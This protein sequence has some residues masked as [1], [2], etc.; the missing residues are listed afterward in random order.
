MKKALLALL[1]LVIISNAEAQY[2]R[3]VIRFR[4]KG[5]NPYSL[6]NPLQFL[7]QRAI[8]RRLKYNI[9]LDST[10]LPVTPSYIDGVRTSGAVTILNASKWLNSVTIQ[11]SDAAA[12]AKINSLPYV[13]ST[14]PIGRRI[15]TTQSKSEQP[16]NRSASERT[17]TTESLLADRYNYG[18][19]FKQVHIHNGE[20][21]HNI[22][23]RGDS[24]IMGLLDDG[25]YQYTTLKAFDSVRQANKVL[26][27]WDFVAREQSV[28]EDDAHGEMV[29]SIIA[30]NVPGNM[31]GTAPAASFYLFRTEDATSEYPI[32]EHN[33]VCGAE[34]LDSAGG[35]VISTSLGYSQFDSAALNHTYADMNGNTTMSAIGA[36]MAAKKGIVVLVAA[37]NEGNAAWHYISSP[38]DADSVIAV[39]AVDVNGN[40]GSFSSYG[41][42]SDGQVK[43]DVA[44]VGVGTVVWSPSNVAAAGNGTS[45][46]CPNMAGL[47]TCLWQGFREFNNMAIINAV[48][49]AGSTV[50][51]PNTRIGYG[52]PDMKKAFTILLKQYATATAT[53]INNCNPAVNWTSKDAAGMRYE[54]ER[55]RSTDTAFAKVY[56]LMVSN[57]T[58]GSHSYQFI[59]PAAGTP[60]GNIT[61]R[62]RQVIDTSVTGFYADYLDTVSVNYAGNCN[63]T[64]NNVLVLYPNPVK[65][66]IVIQVN[67]IQTSPV[68]VRIFSMS[69]QRLYEAKLSP[70]NV[71]SGYPLPTTNLA[72]GEYIVSVYNGS[73]KVGTARFIK[74]P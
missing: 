7:S 44:S 65:G 22:G 73:G 56:E 50:A 60:A 17:A 11:T 2:T 66:N 61:Y 34:R 59:D 27:T 46:A 13:I 5:S 55:K 67:T 37:G 15:A 10:D 25:F 35:D 23:L 6:S 14:G 29:F 45:F 39:G 33:W 36:D 42:S 51:T 47:V 32:E 28:I 8:D 20:F 68:T 49:Q 64:A 72:S 19:S 57:T 70:S 30:A 31:V 54:I 62:I 4:N 41:P 53:T 26:G 58:Y 74:L 1:T 48:R 40:V 38:A 71:L 18:F 52:I 24:M 43:P 63:T 21:L 16:T 12:L 3:Y 69:G 9:P